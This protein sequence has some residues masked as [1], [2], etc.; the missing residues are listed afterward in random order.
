ML[1]I[2]RTMLWC[3]AA[4]VLVTGCNAI[5]GLPSEGQLVD[6]SLLEDAVPAVDD[7]SVDA[8]IV[9]VDA[10]PDSR[11]DAADARIDALDACVR[12]LMDTVCVGYCNEKLVSDGCGGSYGCD[13]DTNYCMG[14][15]CDTTTGT[16]CTPDNATDCSQKCGLIVN[17]CGQDVECSSNGGITCTAPDTCVSN[18]CS[19]TNCELGISRLNYCKLL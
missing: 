13:D 18:H 16:C 7:A 3:A 12:K 17:R 9:L 1:A 5:L 19:T 10:T 4:L 15:T 11:I 6:A 2:L 14:Q 8:P